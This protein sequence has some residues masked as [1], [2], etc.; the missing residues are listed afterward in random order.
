VSNDVADA[1]ERAV[2]ALP[3]AYREA[4]QLTKMSGLSIAEAASVLG[5]TETAVKLRVHRGYN[6]LRKELERFSRSA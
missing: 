6:L 3:E 2:D 5:T 1:I 4:I